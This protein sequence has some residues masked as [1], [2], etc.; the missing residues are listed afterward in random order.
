MKKKLFFAA[1]AIVALASCSDNEFIGDNSPTTQQ[2]N[3]ADE[4]QFA[5]NVK[6]TTRADLYGADAADKLGGE[7]IVLGVKGDGT[8]VDQTTVFK[9]YT[10]NWTANTAG[11]TESNT[12]DWEYVN[13]SNYFGLSG[14]QAIKYW[15]YSTTA[16]DFAAY[17]VGKGNTLIKSGD[18]AANKILASEIT[19]AT[20]SPE[21]VAG[22]TLKGSREDLTECYI[23]DM[24]TVAKADYGKEVELEFRSLATKV[25]MA[26]YETIPGYSVK[27]V[28]FYSTDQG[29]TIAAANYA[30]A[31]SATL[32]G[33][34]FYAGGEYKVTYP[35]I[36]SGNSGDSD[37]KKAHV[38][39][40]STGYTTATTQTFGT[41]NYT[42]GED[43]LATGGS[44]Y[45]KRASNDPSFAGTGTYYQTVLPKE[46][47]TV[48]EMCVDYTLVSTDGSAEEITVHGAK[49]FVPAV[50]T[51]WMPN[52]AYTYIFKISDNSNGYTNPDGTDPAGLYPITFDAIVLDSE[53]TGKQT[54]ITTVATPSITTYQKG[55][56]YST[57]NSYDNTKNIYV[58]V[59]NDGTLITDLNHKDGS[60]KYDKTFF[61]KLSAEKT[62][63][64][65]MDALNIRT[66]GD[67]TTVVGRNELT[68]TPATINLEIEAIPGEDGND[69]KVDKGKA[70]ELD[71]DAAGT[72]AFVYLVSAGTA[73]YVYTAVQLTGADAPSDFTTAY[74]KQ[75]A[76]N[77]FTLC[78]AG[79]YVQNKYYYKRYQD[80]NNV[81]AVKVIKV[82]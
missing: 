22:F 18:L 14:A 31:T 12:A 20:S 35:K 71:P 30:S 6:N 4:I 11:K 45:L 76:P 81:Y 80:L 53:E 33:A 39:I 62:E 50:Y 66:S 79:D 60:S 54:T 57:K 77:A 48:L 10:V 82:E 65:V 78:V 69:I 8:G 63:A 3:A 73:G 58:Q 41:L 47:G 46:E 21:A 64:D 72:Y 75:T 9:S 36:G 52:Y 23:T 49:A 16:Y 27:D 42:T 32:I 68:L 28:K 25:R 67:A 19:Y 40:T 43:A 15:D 56:V 2:E 70:A 24:K 17:S 37:Y 55:H 26:I 61:Y 51:K 1:V 38:S 5:F 34:A 7:F 59:Q 44:I 13:R 29:A 74:Y